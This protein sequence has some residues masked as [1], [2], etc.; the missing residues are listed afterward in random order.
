VHNLYPNT[1]ADE[2]EDGT[3]NPFRD[4]RVRRAAN[5]A[6]NRQA[7]I[8]NLM[9]GTEEMALFAFNGTF[10]YPTPEQKADITFP[11][12][13]EG[14]KA[15][16]AEAG[17]ADGF[18]TTIHFNAGWGTGTSELVLVASQD[19][20]AIGIR[21]SLREIPASDYYTD[22]EVRAR[23]GKPGL[24]WFTANTNPDPGSMLSCCV[25]GGV[26]TMS[27]ASQKVLDLAKA[28]QVELDPEVRKG[29]IQQTFIEHTRES[30]FIFFVE[31]KE[32]VLTRSNINW[33]AGAVQ[34]R[35]DALHF[36]T[37]KLV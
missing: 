37:Q 26:Y 5:M 36:A 28:Q 3:P 22:A 29:L 9:T 24:W 12:D 15:L 27:L 19:L 14:A 31:P 1:W 16:M 4:E 30:T 20:A 11:Y 8:D 21:T 13:P 7:V 10:G 33:P 6:L 32:A 35:S 23:P 25:I 17:F 18:D 34:R 2:L